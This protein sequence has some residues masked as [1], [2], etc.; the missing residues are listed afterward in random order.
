MFG[1]LFIEVREKRGLVYH[2]SAALNAAKNRG[3]ITAFAGTTSEN[4]KECLEVILEQM[5]SLRAGITEVELS[6][7]KL[8][9]V[10]RMLIQSEM[11]SVRAAGNAQDWW[12][13]SRI[14]SLSEVREGVES[15]TSEDI[16]NFLKAH[17]LDNFALVCLGSKDISKEINLQ[18]V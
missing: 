10:S 2:V 3:S 14:R 11:M 13:V 1:R 6:R 7:A 5:N 17:P 8:D 4:G 12:N 15:V 18:E 9:I 16:T